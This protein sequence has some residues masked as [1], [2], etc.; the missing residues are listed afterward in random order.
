MSALARQE[1]SPNA[2]FKFS[3]MEADRWRREVQC[4]RRIGK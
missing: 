3:D 4:A 1:W 2:V